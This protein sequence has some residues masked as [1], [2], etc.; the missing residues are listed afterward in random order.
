MPVLDDWE[1]QNLFA[2]P[3]SHGDDRALTN[4]ILRHWKVIYDGEAEAWADAPDDYRTFFKQQLRWEKSFVGESLVLVGHTW[5]SH[6]I[7]FPAVLVATVSGIVSPLVMLCQLGWE[8]I[9]GG[10]APVF[11]LICLYLLTASYALFY[12]SRRNDGNWKHAISS[13]FFYVGFSLQIYRATIPTYTPLAITA[14]QNP[15]LPGL[16]AGP[17][18]APAH[19]PATFFLCGGNTCGTSGLA[20]IDSAQ[21]EALAIQQVAD[22]FVIGDHTWDHLNIGDTT[23]TVNPF[24]G[25]PCATGQTATVTPTLTTWRASLLSP[26]I[27]GLC[28]QFEIEDTANMIHKVTGFWPQLFRPPF[29]DYAWPEEHHGR[30]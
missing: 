16:I 14:L 6:P 4:M 10:T 25:M 7:A 2:R 19:I 15:A 21:G 13:A 5:R 30:G 20:R 26:R 1:N 18:G 28:P 24:D 27:T 12:R 22:G 3:W 17:D 11:Y 29:G 8:P 23:D 9:T